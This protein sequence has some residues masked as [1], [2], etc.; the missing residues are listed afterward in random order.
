MKASWDKE[1]RGYTV[2]IKELPVKMVLEFMRNLQARH[3]FCNECVC[4]S[5]ATMVAKK[6]Y[7]DDCEGVEY[8]A[9][10]TSGPV[11]YQM[12]KMYGVPQKVLSSARGVLRHNGYEFSDDVCQATE[13]SS[14]ASLMWFMRK[15]SR[16]GKQWFTNLMVGEGGTAEG[17]LLSFSNE[18]EFRIHMLQTIV[19][20]NPDAAFTD[21]TFEIN[22][23]FEIL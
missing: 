6:V 15:A 16:A 7:G 14:G 20:K 9:D 12:L 13:Q 11:V 4:E 10:A 21:I 19:D 5:I 18:F 3:R 8:D 22:I 23:T 2:H 1:D 17:S